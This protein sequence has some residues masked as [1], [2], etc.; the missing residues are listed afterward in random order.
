MK[1]LV[2]F[3]ID[4]TLIYHVGKITS[5]IERYTKPME[6][7]YGIKIAFHSPGK[8]NGSIDRKIAWDELV[9]FHTITRKMFLRKFSSY[10]DSRVRIFQ[11]HGT[12]ERIHT[13]IPE[14]V[15]LVHTLNQFPD[16]Y[17][18]GLL[19]GN[20]KKIADWK[21]THAEFPYIFSFGLYGEEAD[22]RIALARLVFKKAKKELGLSF[23]PSDI[24]VIGDT[25]H[26][27]RCGRAIGAFTIGVMT[28]GH[29]ASEELASE[30]PDLLV[31]T[32]MD[33]AVLDYFHL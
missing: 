21:L 33:P 27:I 23:K 20:A 12:I 3:D 26:D 11:K 6:E 14:A 9:P 5:W 10:I 25:I 18:L 8:H 30:K 17:V 16:T 32:L 29:E 28:G 13:C 24:I 31:H 7:I 15:R 19:T 1:K 2:L 4:G 22:D